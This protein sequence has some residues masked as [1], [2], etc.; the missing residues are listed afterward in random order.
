[1]IGGLARRYARALLWLARE[2]AALESTGEDLAKVALAFGDDQLKQVLLNLAKNAVEAMPRGGKLSFA[3]AR[4]EHGGRN[5]AVIALHDTGPGLPE[6]VREQLFQPA[7]STKGGEHAGL[8]L[9]I[10]Q[11]LVKS[12]GGEIE[13]DS[14]PGGSTFR[15]YLPMADMG[16]NQAAL[17]PGSQRK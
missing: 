16:Q 13:Y 10:S 1:M 8:G 6:Q 12:M 4:S 5:C 17:Q 2:E 14:S 7:S 9:Y 15:I 11:N 3:T